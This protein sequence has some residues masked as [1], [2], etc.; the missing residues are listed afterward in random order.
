MT[1]QGSNTADTKTASK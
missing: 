1:H